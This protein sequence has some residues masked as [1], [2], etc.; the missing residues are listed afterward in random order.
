MN[1]NTFDDVIRTENQSK[2]FE[3]ELKFFDFYVLHKYIAVKHD[4]R[5]NVQD[6]FVKFLRAV[7]ANQHSSICLCQS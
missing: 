2:S 7:F 3:K 4:A 1:M 6:N 5:N